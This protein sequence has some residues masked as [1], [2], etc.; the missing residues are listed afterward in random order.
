M[1]CYWKKRIKFLSD[2]RHFAPVHPNNKTVPITACND[3]VV[4][5]CSRCHRPMCDNH[6]FKE[7]VKSSS[8]IC[9]YCSVDIHNSYSPP[10]LRD[11]YAQKGLIP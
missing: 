4:R 10:H 2:G 11:T 1:S 7:S 3:A 5:N 6:S 9:E 8:Y